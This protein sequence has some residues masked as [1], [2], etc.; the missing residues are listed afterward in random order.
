MVTYIAEVYLASDREREAV[1]LLASK[2][3]D[4]PYLVPL[5]M[6]QAEAFWAMEQYEYA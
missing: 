6:K 2:I 3:K 4:F 1:T 5:L